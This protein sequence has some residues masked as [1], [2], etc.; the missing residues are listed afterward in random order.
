VKGPPTTPISVAT[1]HVRMML[2]FRPI[3]YM[4]NTIPCT[5]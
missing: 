1:L 5:R 2:D 3:Y 4:Y